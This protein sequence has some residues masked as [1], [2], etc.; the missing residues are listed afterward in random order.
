MPGQYFT[1]IV[2]DVMYPVS[3]LLQKN[4]WCQ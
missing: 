4:S 2:V 3:N 1:A